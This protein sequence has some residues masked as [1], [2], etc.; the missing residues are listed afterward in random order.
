MTKFAIILRPK[1][2]QK[3]T[4]SVCFIS[5]E[6]KMHGAKFQSSSQLI[7]KTQC[8]YW[9]ASSHW[10]TRYYTQ[11]QL[12]RRISIFNYISLTNIQWV[13]SAQT[14]RYPE[15]IFFELT[16]DVHAVSAVLVRCHKCASRVLRENIN[17]Y[18][19][20]GNDLQPSR[21]L[22]GLSVT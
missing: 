21:Y 20:I 14:M 5:V 8:T 7:W 1:G 15:V 19:N 16:N 13:K 10:L 9:P 17:I 2:L 4:S 6:V 12:F 18:V 22:R 11:K 3:R